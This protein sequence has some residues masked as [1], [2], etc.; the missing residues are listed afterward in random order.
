[1]LE[2]KANDTRRNCSSKKGSQ[3]FFPGDL[4][5]KK[6][7]AREDAKFPR[8]IKRSPHTK[9]KKGLRKF[10]ARFLPLSKLK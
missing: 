4:Q 3:N 8:K 10:S 6:V 5:K 7:F 9:N 1:M 2:A